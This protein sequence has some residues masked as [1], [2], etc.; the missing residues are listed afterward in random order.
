MEGAGEGTARLGSKPSVGSEGVSG[1]NPS[2][3]T[4]PEMQNAHIPAGH[5][6]KAFLGEQNIISLREGRLV[7]L[8]MLPFVV[9]NW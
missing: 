2:A 8:F 1:A 4:P 7:W 9:G 5:S 6:I 3:L